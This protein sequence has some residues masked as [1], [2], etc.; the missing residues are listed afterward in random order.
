MDADGASRRLAETCRGRAW[1]LLALLAAC[2]PAPT[3]IR[4]PAQF[5]GTFG[6]G[7]SGLGSQTVVLASD[8]R[9]TLT[10]FC[11][12]GGSDT[13]GFA[14][15][16]GDVL[17]LP[18]DRDWLEPQ[19]EGSRTRHRLYAVPWGAR[20]YL[21]RDDRLT[22]FCNAVNNG[23]EPRKSSGGFWL[24]A[25]DEALRAPGL[26]VV[27][28]PWRLY[29]LS[30][31]LEARTV[32]AVDERGAWVEL[33][34]RDG[35]IEGMVLTLHD[36][37]VPPHVVALGSPPARD[38]RLRIA[39]LEPERCLVQTDYGGVEPEPIAT[40]LLVTCGTDATGR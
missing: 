34:A 31:R 16:E 5:V 23:W 15:L 40:G 14:W 11:C 2:H 26:P 21:V 4:L 6:T 22:E 39:R 27:P 9:F 38:Q 35:L 19:A 8:G 10:E 20:M 32:S 25:G 1:L 3:G 37:P 12:T 30:C 33:G 18:D 7:E 13:A 29:L 28:G 17:V 36:V 24:R